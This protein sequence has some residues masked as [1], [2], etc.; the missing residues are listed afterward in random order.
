MLNQ[1]EF[2]MRR[3]NLLAQMADNS[4]AILFTSPQYHRSADQEHRFY[5]DNDFYYFTG[6]IEPEAVAVIIKSAA[7]GNRYVL[8][9]RAKD[10]LQEQ[11]SGIRVGQENA[12]KM[13]GADE[14][15]PISEL[16]EKLPALLADKESLYYVWGRYF[17][18]DAIVKLALNQVRRKVRAGAKI[19]DTLINLEKIVH[20]MRLIK[21][22]GEV[23][24]LRKAINISVEAHKQAMRICRPGVN[25]YEI[26][27]AMIYEFQRRGCWDEAY[28]LII[29]GGDNACILHY[30]EDNNELHDGELLL[31]DAGGRYQFYDADLTRTFPVNGKYTAEQEALYEVVLHAQ[32]KALEQVAP[33]K[34]WSAMAD[35][36]AFAIT[37]GLRDVGILKGNVQDLYEQQAYASFYIHRIG[38]WLGMDVHDVGR[39]KTNGAWRPF[40]PGMVTT[41]EPGVYVKRGMN[42]DQKWWG[43]GIRIEDNV[44]VTEKGHEVLSAALPKEVADIEALMAE[45]VHA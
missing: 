12:M 8:F 19:P 34:A 40:E 9:S 21:S 11:W 25:E 16:A 43:I 22:A 30:I 26:R 24:L 2:K 45:N 14:A 6:F 17:D 29:A 27:A 7:Q 1:N 28:E 36:A 37:E 35:A 31:V 4:V 33:G 18:Y 42:V 10:P 44:L 32:K 38:H 39:Y 23:E 20:E 5:P 13:F 41:V 15:Y 3:Q